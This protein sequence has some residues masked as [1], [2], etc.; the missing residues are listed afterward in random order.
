[1][2]K[3][4][5]QLWELVSDGVWLACTGPRVHSLAQMGGGRVK[6]MYVFLLINFILLP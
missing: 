5:I 4:C 6:H 3:K 2:G 1:M